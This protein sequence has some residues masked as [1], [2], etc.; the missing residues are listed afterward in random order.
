M[1]G[2]NPLSKATELIIATFPTLGGAAGAERT[3]READARLENLERR[4]AEIIRELEALRRESRGGAP[5][6]KGPRR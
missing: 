1:K 5:K 2:E 3:L 4:L 6:D